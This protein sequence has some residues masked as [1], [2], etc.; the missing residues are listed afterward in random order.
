M[1]A[2]ASRCQQNAPRPHPSATPSKSVAQR[3]DW[4]LSQLVSRY[5]LCFVLLVVCGLA[6]AQTSQQ[7]FQSSSAKVVAH[8]LLNKGSQSFKT[9][10]TATSTEHDILGSSI[11]DGS[12][13]STPADILAA[14]KH[15]WP[16]GY[17][18]VCAVIKDQWPDLRYWIEYH[19]CPTCSASLS[20][21]TA[22][23]PESNS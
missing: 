21:R 4:T 23:H 12:S 22:T 10:L 3:N 16:D 2:V 18:A 7:P 1:Q 6:I 9:E 13:N 19:R 5:A 8:R 15:T 14:Q 20:L 11:S 17:V